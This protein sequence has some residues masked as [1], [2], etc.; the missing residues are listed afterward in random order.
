MVSAL[1][2]LLAEIT[3]LAGQENASHQASNELT[4]MHVHAGPH[5]IALQALLRGPILGDPPDPDYFANTFLG[6]S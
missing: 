3:L 1:N 4:R 5:R 2:A 6:S